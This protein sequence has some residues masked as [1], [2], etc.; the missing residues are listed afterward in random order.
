MP[1]E[2]IQ[3]PGGGS[4]IIC[5]RRRPKQKRCFYC[6]K[7]SSWLCDYNT[8]SIIT[9]PKGAG[10]TCDRPICADHRVNRGP[11][12]DWCIVHV[13]EELRRGE[14]AH[15]EQ[16]A[17]EGYLAAVAAPPAVQLDLGF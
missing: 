2:P 4:A 6:S 12:L 15:Q 10:K 3:F 5:G 14:D 11:D 17:E 16:A 9:G 7:A 1:C 8:P 13:E